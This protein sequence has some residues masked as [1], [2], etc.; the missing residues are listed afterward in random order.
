MVSLLARLFIKE[1]NDAKDPA[2]RQAYGILCGLW[3]FS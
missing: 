2:V 3:G 1:Q